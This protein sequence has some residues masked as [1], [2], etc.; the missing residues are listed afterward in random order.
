MGRAGQLFKHG[1]ERSRQCAESSQSLLVTVQFGARRQVAIKEEERDFL[2]CAFFR[3]VIDGIPAVSQPHPLFADGGDRR[4]AGHDSSQATAFFVC[5]HLFRL[6]PMRLNRLR[7]E[8]LQ[9]YYGLNRGRTKQYAVYFISL[10][11]NSGKG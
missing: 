5:A 6:A 2:E 1:F 9:D 7:N 3:K 4:L 10:Q 8:P 11:A